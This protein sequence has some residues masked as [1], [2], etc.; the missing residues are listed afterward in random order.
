MAIKDGFY[1]ITFHA[2]IE[3]MGGIVVVN[4]DRV[5]G[6]DGNFLY[7]GT[8]QQDGIAL[9]A[10]IVVSAHVPNALTTFG[11]NATRFEL[12][13]SGEI[14]GAGFQ[15]RGPSPV[16]GQPPIQIQ[17]VFLAPATL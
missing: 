15:L 5:Q 10:A 7:S 2:L 3:G 11:M 12:K 13:L 1:K 8:L 9:S 14:S 17:G 6:A 16:P 4:G